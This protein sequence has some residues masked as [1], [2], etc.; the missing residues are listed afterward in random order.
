MPTETEL[1]LE[2]TQQGVSYEVLF[3][4]SDIYVLERFDTSA[5]NPVNEILLKLNLPDHRSI[6]TDSKVTPIK[7]GRMTKPYSSPRFIANCF[8]L[9]IYKDGDGGL[10]N[11]VID[12]AANMNK[13]LANLSPLRLIRIFKEKD[14]IYSIKYQ[15]PGLSKDDVK[16]IVKDGMLFI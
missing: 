9:G 15:M 2:Q 6:L 7:H 14:E 1:T 8:I 11:A 5:G 10:T 12:A 16:I 4:E 3:D 13:V